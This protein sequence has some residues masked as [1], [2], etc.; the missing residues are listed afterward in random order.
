MTIMKT[1]ED[2]LAFV[3]TLDDAWDVDKRYR[4]TGDK[5]LAMIYVSRGG[6][7][8][9]RGVVFTMNFSRPEAFIV[10]CFGDADYKGR[11]TLVDVPEYLETVK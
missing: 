2:V 5:S 9:K 7:G 8:R 3:E 1:K 11:L 10:D 6:Y 4:L